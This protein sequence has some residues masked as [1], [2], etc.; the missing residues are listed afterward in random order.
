M[1]IGCPTHCGATNDSEA[2]YCTVCGSPIRG[3]TR[4]TQYAAQL[5]NQGLTA[6]QTGELTKARELFAAVVHWT[7]FDH[8]AR[9]A[10][11]LANYELSDRER[12]RYH[13]SL[14]LTQHPKDILA[15]TGLSRLDNTDR[16]KHE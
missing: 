7:P 8:G 4:L 6:A 15:L 9:N 11:A 14:V 16:I 1:N 13:W 10:L 12:A 2:D 5:F 3:H